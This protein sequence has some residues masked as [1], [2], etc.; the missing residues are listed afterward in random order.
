M[1]IL[2]TLWVGIRSPLM[3]SP[4]AEPCCLRR[5]S[6]ALSSGSLLSVR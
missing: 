2:P 1:P 6:A 4:I 5:I 3:M